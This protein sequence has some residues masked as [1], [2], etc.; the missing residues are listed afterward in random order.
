MNDSASSWY[1]GATRVSFIALARTILLKAHL[2]SQSFFF[3][4]VHLIGRD[5]RIIEEGVF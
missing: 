3:V 5:R 4:T 2:G 1:K